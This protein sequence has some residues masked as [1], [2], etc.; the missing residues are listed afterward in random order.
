MRYGVRVCRDHVGRGIEHPQQAR[1]MNF[2]SFL[3][4]SLGL[5]L[6]GDA[7]AQPQEF[8]SPAL[9]QVD[10]GTVV[11][12]QFLM[13]SPSL[14]G[15]AVGNRPRTENREHRLRF[16]LSD[17][18]A[19]SPDGKP[20]DGPWHERLAK[21]SPVLLGSY[22]AMLNGQAVPRR[23]SLNLPKSF[24]KLYREDALVLVG[25]AAPI[26][27]EPVPS[28][29]ALPKSPPPRFGSALVWEDG[30]LHVFETRENRIHYYAPLPSQGN[31][32]IFQTTETTI[33]RT[34][35]PGDAR[36]LDLS[37]RPVPTASL[38]TTFRQHTPVAVSADGQ[39]VDPFYLQLLKP[40][41]LVVIVPMPSPSRHDLKPP[42]PQ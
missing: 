9:A 19:F 17:V 14:P 11:I 7:C 16:R 27:Q 5:L 20:V 35:P 10:N 15:D 38:A 30:Q 36:V 26:K 8:A 23:P 25:N 39:S 41:R 18:Q 22:A 24:A 28:S 37:G 21:E 33:T 12:R 13:D 3:L 2:R 29:P 31:T 42:P 34:L 40:D 6:G 4:L 32:H 1:A